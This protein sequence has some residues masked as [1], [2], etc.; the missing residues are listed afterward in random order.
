MQ[1]GELRGPRRLAAERGVFKM[2]A[3]D[4]R[5]P[6][7]DLI[8]HRRGLDH[9][10][11]DEVGLERSLVEGADRHAVPWSQKLSPDDAALL[12]GK[13]EHFAECYVPMHRS[14]WAEA[15]STVSTEDRAT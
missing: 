2:S 11:L 3:V 9:P 4:Q 12:D 15:P 13:T 10:P 14:A 5:A 8:A 1:P 6:V 7:Y